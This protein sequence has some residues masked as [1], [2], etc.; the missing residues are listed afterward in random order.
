MTRQTLYGTISPL[1]VRVLSGIAGHPIQKYAVHV[2]WPP[3]A[4]ETCYDTGYR[5]NQHIGK[6]SHL[7]CVTVGRPRRP[8]CQQGQ[9][10]SNGWL[11]DIAGSA[12]FSDVEKRPHSLSRLSGRI[13][14]DGAI[15]VTAQTH[16]TQ[17]S[18]P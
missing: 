7:S 4:R 5:H 10:E 8:E 17:V 16:R 2:L 1:S 18:Q 15:Q 6:R 3:Y 12:A 11:F 14:R 13:N 9:H